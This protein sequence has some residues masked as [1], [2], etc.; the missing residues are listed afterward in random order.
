MDSITEHYLVLLGIASTTT[1]LLSLEITYALD[2]NIPSQ[3]LVRASVDR[4]PPDRSR[5]QVTLEDTTAARSISLKTSLIHQLTH[6]VL[7]HARERR[8]G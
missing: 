6:H 4:K 8:F 1:T 3:F 5:T 7:V 2:A